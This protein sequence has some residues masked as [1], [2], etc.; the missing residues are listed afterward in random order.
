[1]F[2]PISLQKHP[3]YPSPLIDEL[4]TYYSAKYSNI[5]YHCGV[6]NVAETTDYYPICDNCVQNKKAK[7]K[8][9]TNNNKKD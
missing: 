7:V 3:L 1:M 2:L 9:R 6:G 4:Q 8:R 5:C